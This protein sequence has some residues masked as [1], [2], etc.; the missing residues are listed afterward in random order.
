MT[1]YVAAF[2]SVRGTDT[3]NPFVQV[4]MYDVNDLLP[5]SAV[6]LSLAEAVDLQIV[7]ETN[8]WENLVSTNMV[9]S[10]IIVTSPFDPTVLGIRSVTA[11]GARPGNSAPRFVSWGFKSERTRADIRA[12]FKRVGEISET[13]INGDVPTLAMLT[14]LEGF[15][16]NLSAELEVSDGVSAFSAIPVVVKR[17]KYITPEGRDAYR[18][19]NDPSEYA[20]S[21]ATNWTFQAVTSQNSRKK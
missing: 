13:D 20:F 18:L 1:L 12:G 4:F 14:I 9:G 10:R 15:A 17:V 2:E 16:A 11:V 21:F 6:A 5:S 3:S 19:P 7:Q 8:G